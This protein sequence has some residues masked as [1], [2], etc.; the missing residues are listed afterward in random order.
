MEVGIQL[1]KDNNVQAKHLQESCIA[2]RQCRV[3]TLEIHLFHLMSFNVESM[4]VAQ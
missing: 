4:V 1:K 3:K 2:L